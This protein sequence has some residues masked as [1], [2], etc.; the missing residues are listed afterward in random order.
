MRIFSLQDFR[1]CLVVHIYTYIS[2]VFKLVYT[3][4]FI[5]TFLGFR[6]LLL[7]L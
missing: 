7:W 2:K 6:T 1:I 3:D 4:A 5:K